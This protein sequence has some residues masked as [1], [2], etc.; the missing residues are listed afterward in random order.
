MLSKKLVV[1]FVAFSFA[2]S[3]CSNSSSGSGGAKVSATSSEASSMF[4]SVSELPK[5]RDFVEYAETKDSDSTLPAAQKELLKYCQQTSAST[6]DSSNQTAE[7]EV[8]G[9]G[10]PISYSLESQASKNGSQYSANVNIDYQVLN[11]DFA[12]Q[13]EV[14]S[15]D[16]KISLTGTET[17]FLNLTG[18]INC[19]IV[20]KTHGAID[21]AVTLQMENSLNS[22]V[23]KVNATI[24]NGI[25]SAQVSILVKSVS[26]VKTTEILIDGVPASDNAD[27]AGLTDLL[28][29]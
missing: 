26:G 10:C 7:V 28:A 24:V 19:Q 8:A 13:V 16:C 11:S 2:I 23:V 25:K 14:Q 21:V 29:M 5:I 12:N 18:N 6:G 9:P 3:G 4:N 20:S 15:A 17:E 27:L 1:L 22:N